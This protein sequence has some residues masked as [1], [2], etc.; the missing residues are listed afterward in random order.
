MRSLLRSRASAP[1]AQPNR[2]TVSGHGVAEKRSTVR[3][4][5]L[6]YALR[7]AMERA[8]LTGKRTANL[9]DWSESR[10]SRFL[11]GKLAATEVEVSAMAAVFGVTG[12]ER[13]RLLHLTRAQT[14]TR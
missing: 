11:T 10:V 4:R 13:D 9:L 2:P 14:L 5:Q 3:S 12:A 1:Q 7:S 6:G 8:G